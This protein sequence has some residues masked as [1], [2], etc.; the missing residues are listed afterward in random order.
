[1]VVTVFFDK[2]Y[3]IEIEFYIDCTHMDRLLLLNVIICITGTSVLLPYSPASH[4][5]IH[6]YFIKQF[7][8]ELLMR[9]ILEYLT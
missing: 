3:G 7:E 6:A 2:A 9:F 8:G 4:G 5:L 1:M